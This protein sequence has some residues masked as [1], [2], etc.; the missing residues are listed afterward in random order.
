MRIVKQSAQV[1]VPES[2]MKHI[3]RIGRIC[4]K[5]EDKTGEGTDKRFVKML[6]DHDHHAMLEHYRF[7]IKVSPTIYEELL[8]CNPRHFEFSVYSGRFIISFNARALINLVEGCRGIRSDHQY[9]AIR[10]VR[11]ELIAHIVHKYD[12][13]ELFGINREDKLLVSDEV[14]FL[15]NNPFAM[16]PEEWRI[17]GWMSIHM[18]TDRG[19]THEI[20]RHREETSF[21]QESTR[22]CNYSKDKFGNEITVIDQEFDG[23]NRLF[24]EWS[25]TRAEENYFKLLDKNATPQMARSVLPTCLK[26]EIVMT[27]P[28]YE[29]EHFFNLRMHGVAGTPHPMIKELSEFAYQSIQEVF[30]YE[31]NKN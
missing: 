7:I 3:E 24:W 11:D 23:A 14:E 2:P 27:A 13:Y 20:V 26:T 12:C 4:Y 15:E 6:Y 8:R 18:I 21:A 9:H 19:I 5:S 28:V 17:H 31:L 1:L 22:Y 10:S 25:C 30:F 16:N 29:W